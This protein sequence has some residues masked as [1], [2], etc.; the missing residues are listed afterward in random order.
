MNKE[1]TKIVFILNG[2][3]K[4]RCLKRIE[5]FIDN[6]YKVDAYGFSWDTDIPNVSDKREL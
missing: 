4:S 5:E 3:Y 1:K 2:V 6:G